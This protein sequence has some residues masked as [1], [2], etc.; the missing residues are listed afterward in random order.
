MKGDFKMK[1][2]KNKKYTTIA[3]YACIVILFSIVC[4]YFVLHFETLSSFTRNLL[5][6]LSPMLYGAIIA[7]ILNPLLKSFETK[8]FITKD[9]R[10]ARKTAKEQAQKSGIT[11]KFK[12]EKIMNDAAAAALENSKKVKPSAKKGSAQIEKVKDLR[13]KKKKNTGDRALS[14]ICTYLI[15]I[16]II[17]LLFSILLPQLWE[18][19]SSLYQNVS[20][21]IKNLP[22]TITVLTAKYQWF[23]TIYGFIFE[24][25]DFTSTGITSIVK[26]ILDNSADIISFLQNFIGNTITQ[27]KNVLLGIIFSVYFL[28][29]KEMLLGQANKMLDALAGPK[30][31]KFTRHIFVQFDR[32]FGQFLRG[33]ILDSAIIGV[34]SFFV[35]WIFN[36]PYYQLIAVIVGITNIIP[37][38]GPFIGA[39]PS[40]I[41]IFLVDPVKALLFIVLILII[42]QVDGNLIGPHI[43]G[44][45][46]DL[47][48][49]WIMIAIIVMSGL[50]G[51]FGMFFGVPIFA[52]IYTL[53]SEQIYK[54][55][56]IKAARNVCEETSETDFISFLESKE[57]PEE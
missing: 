8:I 15:F 13:K 52:V 55:L 37:F 32:K 31:A 27:V 38:F 29:Y 25:T 40:A 26:R 30:T 23:R 3:I 33:K 35:F 57:I 11:S 45:T 9:M 36:I 39:I 21:I 42:Q 34:L 56:A 2:E 28:I 24:N 5:S 20:T 1:F 22:T 50:L 51:V 4:L 46:I 19:L 16:A 41:I 10:A 44:S 18:S 53:V 49:L 12:L 43:L 7:Y 14:L 54:R 47:N 48:P 17:V 6:I